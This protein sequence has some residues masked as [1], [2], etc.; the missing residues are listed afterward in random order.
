MADEADEGETAPDG[1]PAPPPPPD[2]GEPGLDDQK[3]AARRE[4]LAKKEAKKLAKKQKKDDKVAA[5]EAKAE[6]E[7]AGAAAEAESSGGGAPPPSS[8]EIKDD[9]QEPL[10]PV[11]TKAPPLSAPWPQPAPAKTKPS[12]LSWSP[13]QPISAVVPPPSR[14]L[15][16]WSD[17]QTPGWAGGS[18]RLASEQRTASWTD[19]NRGWLSSGSDEDT[20][21]PM[22]R[23]FGRKLATRQEE[24]A[25][26]VAER[27]GATSRRRD[28]HF[29]DAL[30]SSLLTHLLKIEG[31]AAE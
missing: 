21:D 24:T 31:G 19:P 6:D 15:Q 25:E 3:A 16:T 12:L 22:F 4:K 23:R 18:S 11:W 5:K 27:E 29:A 1:A 20:G 26:L 14:P 30:A 9:T 10:P 17:P 7:G 2:P 13:G 28:C 8:R